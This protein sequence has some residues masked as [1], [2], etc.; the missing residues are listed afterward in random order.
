MDFPRNGLQNHPLFFG[1]KEAP[2]REI[3]SAIA[4]GV[5]TIGFSRVAATSFSLPSGTQ[6]DASASF[7][8]EIV[9]LSEKYRAKITVLLG[10]A[11]DFYADPVFMPCDYRIGFVHSVVADDGAIC[12]LDECAERIRAD[13]NAH[14]GGNIGQLIRRYFE[15]VA[16]LV[17][18]TRCNYVADFDF[19]QTFNQEKRLFDPTLPEYRFAVLD[20]MEALV[21]E[22]IAFGIELR[23]DGS[24]SPSPDIVR[25][26]AAH[27][28]RFSLLSGLSKADLSECIR[29]AK[30]C[31]AGGFSYFVQGSWK[32]VLP[33]GKP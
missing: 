18:K 16:L 7:R 24:F 26:F 13:V 8:N 30:S 17:Q 11:R 27:G 29:Y 23:E 9:A 6:A 21:R 25:W 2:E 4:A 31:G 10:E 28:A 32:T 19:L 15:T 33:G 3:L 12:P 14:F 20:A 22:D 5:Q 1:E